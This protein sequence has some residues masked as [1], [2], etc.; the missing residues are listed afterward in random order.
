MLQRLRM[1]LAVVVIITMILTSGCTGGGGST[2]EE[3]TPTPLPPPEVAE[4]PTYRVQR[5]DVVDTV[6]FNGRVSPTVEEELYFEAGGRVVS[7]L[8]KRNEMVEEGQLLAELDNTDLL[9]QLEQATISLNTAQSNLDT[10]LKA[11]EK[12]GSGA[13]GQLD[14]QRLQLQKL[15]GTLPSLDLEVSLAQARLDAA[16]ASPTPEELAIAQSA[17]ESAKNA[18]WAAQAARDS[19][20]GTPGAACDGAQAN[21][22]R[23][24][25]AVRVAELNLEQVRAGATDL[26]ILSLR[27][28]LERAMQARRSADVDIA[29]LVR[30]IALAEESISLATTEVDPQIT[31]AVEQNRLSVERLEAQLAATRIVAPFAGRIT[32]SSV[33]EGVDAQAFKTVMVISDEAELEI[34]AEPT[35]AQLDKMAEGM[36]G[37]LVLSQ[38]P[39]QVLTGLIYQLPYPYGGGGGTDLQ[40]VDKK[41]RISFEIGDLEL[42]PGDLVKVDVTVA[43]SKDALWLP[44]A[45]I[46]TYSGRSFVVVQDGDTERRVDVSIGIQGLDRVE[47][48]EGLE[49][50]QVVVGQ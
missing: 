26:E 47:I 9:R 23:N 18:L 2:K 20:C 34:T 4:R 16:L 29:V 43:E 37:Q 6:T 40:D 21:V 8:V 5:G 45:A 24:E 25:E 17:V 14:I 46:R 35:T 41:T 32:N 50:D 33:T 22:Q 39:G 1:I 44:P 28:A 19:V 11:L 15:R 48:L 38:Y 49:A 36:T 13:Q 10:A 27:A 12:Q 3:P 42:K 7:V 31:A 30:Q